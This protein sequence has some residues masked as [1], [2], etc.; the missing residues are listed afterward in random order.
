[1]EDIATAKGFEQFALLYGA[2]G[3]VALQSKPL[4][5]SEGNLIGVLSTYFDRPHRPSVVETR[6][7][8][9][10]AEESL[11]IT[12]RE[13]SE[14][15]VGTAN[16]QLMRRNAELEQLNTM[17]ARSNQDLEQFA[18]SA[19]HDL[20]EPLRAITA[21]SELLAEEYSPAGDGE[22]GTL[23]Q[24]IVQ[25][26]RRMGDLLGDL[27]AYA[28]LAADAVEEL[29]ITLDLNRVL[30][31][32]LQNLSVTVAESSASITTGTLPIVIAPEFHFLQ[33]FQNLIGNAI[34]YHTRP[35]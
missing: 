33:I 35:N 34:H 30:L 5:N 13:Q 16:E 29:P 25:A 4:F 24:N 28:E 18:C 10:W 23:V 32:V 2:L 21:Y 9:M 12:T 6:I 15:Q 11:R 31:K 1:V 8:K 27:L 19:S 7:V 26:A 3:V 17:L 20:K 22:A 14:H